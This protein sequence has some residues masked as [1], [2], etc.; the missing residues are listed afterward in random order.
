MND[1]IRDEQVIQARA[2]D[3]ARREAFRRTAS[4]GRDAS[5]QAVEATLASI[6]EEVTADAIERRRDKG[7]L[8]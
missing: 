2:A 7:K 5:P 1:D 8:H 3:A 6:S 4:P